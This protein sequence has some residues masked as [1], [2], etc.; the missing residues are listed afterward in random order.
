VTKLGGGKGG[1]TTKFICSHC[2]KTYTVSCTHVRKHLC[3][4]IP[5]DEG[6]TLGGK[7]CEYVPIKDRNKHKKEV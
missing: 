6:K 5:W 2:H 1:G 3:G 7:T 4:I